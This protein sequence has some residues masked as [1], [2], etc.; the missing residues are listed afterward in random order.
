MEESV[1]REFV[2]RRGA[3]AAE[4]TRLGE[5]L[6]KPGPAI[7]P[8]TQI[9]D[10]VQISA[11]AR[12]VGAQVEPGLPSGPIPGPAAL[13]AALAQV[14]SAT[15]LPEHTI[16][17]SHLTAL[18]R[19]L[20]IA[21]PADL[22][23]SVSGAAPDNPAGRLATE[24]LGQ[25]TD[26][27]SGSAAAATRTARIVG[28]AEALIASFAFSGPSASASPA[29]RAVAEILI[30]LL[31]RRG[32]EPPASQGRSAAGPNELPPALFSLAAL[33][34]RRRRHNHE[35]LEDDADAS[36]DEEADEEPGASQPDDYRSNPRRT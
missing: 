27:G 29:E 35:N 14:V 4:L 17:V 32:L 11:E 36:D 8:A 24:W 34:A 1:T 6:A 22:P 33:P 26:I 5:T 28:L 20:A 30:A 9:P 23:I 31:A 21:L 10:T 12:A 25:L 19:Q 2:A 3:M 18:A 16:A 7:P 15:T 13:A